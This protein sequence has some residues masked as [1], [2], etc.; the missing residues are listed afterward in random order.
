MPEEIKD[1]APYRQTHYL[2]AADNFFYQHIESGCSIATSAVLYGIAESTAESWWRK[3]KNGEKKYKTFYQSVERGFADRRKRRIKIIENCASDRTFGDKVIKGDWQA[4]AWAAERQD[5]S[6][7]TKNATRIK[8]NI[9]QQKTSLSQIEDLSTQLMTKVSE[10]EVSGED[11]AVIMN[12]LELRRRMIETSELAK[13][14]A[15]IENKVN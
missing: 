12:V 8:L 5:R 10:G 13:R 15:E 6:E 7:F 11:A 9:D 4:M 1:R 3:G 2:P 14:L